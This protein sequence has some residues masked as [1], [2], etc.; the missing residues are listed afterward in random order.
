MNQLSTETSPYLRQHAE[1]PVQWHPWNA[2]ALERART[3]NKPLLISI[4]YAACHWCHV[5]AH[6]SFEDPAIAA[7]MNKRFINIKI[8]REE[9]P[10]LDAIYQSALAFLGQHGGWPLTMFCT[11]TGEPFWGGTYFPPEPRYGRPGFPQVLTQIADIFHDEHDKVTRNTNT[12]MDALRRNAQPKS[13]GT[14]HPGTLDT[15][16]ETLARLVDRIHGG[17]R[18]APKFLQPSI[19]AFLCWWHPQHIT[20]L[21]L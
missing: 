7:L 2:A 12:L 1:N 10:D 14:I 13:G 19:F 9:R 16:A 17:L 8:D 15:A 11:P 20:L 3:E 21:D 4:G 6:E 5:M 18:G